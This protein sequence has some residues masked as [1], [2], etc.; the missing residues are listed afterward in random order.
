MYRTREQGMSAHSALVTLVINNLGSVSLQPG[1][2]LPGKN[3]LN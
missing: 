3:C 1:A 2:T